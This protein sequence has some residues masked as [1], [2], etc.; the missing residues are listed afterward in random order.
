MKVGWVNP[1]VT[2]DPL[3]LGAGLGR[4]YM[5]K[6]YVNRPECDPL[7]YRVEVLILEGD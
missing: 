6:I 4:L 7:N 3:G 5:K 1:Q 2:R